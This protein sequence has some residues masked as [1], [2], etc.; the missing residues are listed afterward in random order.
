M[1]SEL[2]FY[3]ETRAKKGIL[4]DVRDVVGELT[5]INAKNEIK[6]QNDLA[7]VSGT[8][9]APETKDLEG[10]KRTTLNLT[11]RR[12]RTSSDDYPTTSY[13]DYSSDEIEMSEEGDVEE[14]LNPQPKKKTK[15]SPMFGSGNESKE[16]PAPPVLQNFNTATSQSFNAAIPQISTTNKQNKKQTNEHE[17][18]TEWTLTEQAERNKKQDE[19]TQKNP[20]D[21]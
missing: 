14:M 2:Q 10:G 11:R 21:A 1:N 3:S 4:R 15:K 8:K 13:M 9:T 19:N 7:K 17:K 18:F 16:A 20:N 12:K 5:R 6:S